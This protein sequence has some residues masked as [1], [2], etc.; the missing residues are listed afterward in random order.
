MGSAPPVRP[1]MVVRHHPTFLH[2]LATHLLDI[3]M[4]VVV[5]HGYYLGLD[6]FCSGYGVLIL[7][8]GSSA[9]HVFSEVLLD[10][11]IGLLV[12]S[13]G[14]CSLDFVGFSIAVVDAIRILGHHF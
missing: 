12:V 3:R 14:G 10:V 1:R 11:E 9:A 8:G 4:D 5:L 13:V 6:L 7:A 2:Q